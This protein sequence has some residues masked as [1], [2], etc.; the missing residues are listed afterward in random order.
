MPIFA[1]NHVTQLDTT[2]KY[3]IAFLG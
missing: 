3:I 1:Q 2:I